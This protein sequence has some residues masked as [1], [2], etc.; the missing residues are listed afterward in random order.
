MRIKIVLKQRRKVEELPINTGYLIASSIYHTLSLASE[1]YATD[2]HEIGYG[3]QGE[4]RH[5][6]HFTFSNIQ[7]PKKEIHKE[8]I[9]SYSNYIFFM[10]S[11]PKEEFLQNLVMGL[12]QDGLF[13]IAQSYFEKEL[14][15]TLPE[16]I[17]ENKMSFS[18]MSPLTLSISENVEN[19][20][21]RKHYLRAHDERFPILIRQNLMA[22]YESLTGENFGF[23]EADFQ[24]EFDQAYIQKQEKKG[25]S[26]EKLITIAAGSEKQTRIKALECPFTI[27]AHP[28]L[29]KIGYEC[30]FGDSNSMGFGMVKEMK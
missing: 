23:D 11:S 17:F 22:K 4:R 8:K 20:V 29:I 3:K 14:I 7:F 18:M 30:G 26:I 28:E 24:F 21:R 13:R 6:K 9:I 27:T 5:F 12:F 15:E 10:I 25:R 2:L 16:P 1:S 19:G